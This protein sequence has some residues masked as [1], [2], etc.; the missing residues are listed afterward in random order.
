MSE[1][2]QERKSSDHASMDNPEQYKTDKKTLTEMHEEEMHVDPI[3]MEDL[4]QEKREEK[5]KRGTKDSSSSE[6]KFPE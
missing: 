3:P 4:K 1:K 6:E 2:E 5:D